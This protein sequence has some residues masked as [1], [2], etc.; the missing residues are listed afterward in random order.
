[1]TAKL[2]SL[3][4]PKVPTEQGEPAT[5][6]A[7]SVVCEV[8]TVRARPHR[9]NWARLFKRVFDIDMRHR[10]NSRAGRGIAPS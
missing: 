9:I 8:E 6:A 4:V 3:V 1:M 5:E 2:R 7:A 10:P